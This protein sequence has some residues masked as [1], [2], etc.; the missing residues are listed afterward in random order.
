MASMKLIAALGVIVAAPLWGQPDPAPVTAPPPA[1]S[2]ERICLHVGPL[3]GNIVETVQCW[4]RAEWAEQ[5]V[6][7]DKELP[8][9]GVRPA[10]TS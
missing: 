9:E 1:P 3:T 10:R 2:D 5:G 4:T 6:D 8:K 7:A